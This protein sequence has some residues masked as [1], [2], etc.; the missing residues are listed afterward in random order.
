M[1]NG[2][3]L[4]YF[5]KF[6]VIVIYGGIIMILDF[7]MFVLSK[8][9][10]FTGSVITSASYLK[11]LSKEEESECLRK[12]KEEGDKEARDKLINHNMRLV[13]HIAKKYTGSYEQED[14]LS[15]G[16]IGLIKAV[17]TFE[18]GKGTQ[19]A[20]F[21]S[22][23]IENEILMLLR[24]N[25]KYKNDVYLSD[26]IGSDKDGNEL[27][28]IDILF[29]SEDAVY[30]SVDK[31]FIGEKLKRKMREILSEREY[32]IMCYRYGLKNGICYPQREVAKKLKE[33]PKE[34]KEQCVR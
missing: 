20:T 19:L 1:T 6:S 4:Y 28:L 7:L 12:M 27:S 31:E 11:P 23:C 5:T 9:T 21:A 16:S 24:S 26:T 18:E 32:I 22:R 3:A 2:L 15:V 34:S 13:A 25:K 29:S 8:I 33:L 30:E 14:I 10:F 17:N